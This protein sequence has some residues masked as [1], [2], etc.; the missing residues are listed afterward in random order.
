MNN[1]VKYKKYNSK[2]VPKYEYYREIRRFINKIV[3]S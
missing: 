3:D 2:Y 1:N